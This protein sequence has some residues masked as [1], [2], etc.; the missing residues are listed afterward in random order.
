MSCGFTV[1]C[2]GFLAWL[3][4]NLVNQNASENSFKH[5]DLLFIFNILLGCHCSQQ[6]NS[7]V[8]MSLDEK[9]ITVTK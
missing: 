4:T 8:K 1:F 7:F 3:K 5:P 6:M 2:G 9:Q